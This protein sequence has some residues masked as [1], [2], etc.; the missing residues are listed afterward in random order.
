MQ[1]PLLLAKKMHCPIALFLVQSFLV[2]SNIKKS[3]FFNLYIYIHES[4]Y[5]CQKMSYI[6]IS[7]QT[8]KHTY[9]Y[10]QALV[11]LHHMDFLLVS[12]LLCGIQYIFSITLCTVNQS[13]YI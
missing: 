12:Q 6:Y 5:V 3:F 1:R 4:T 9:R 13:D 11:L 2:L 8:Y 10:A 7:I